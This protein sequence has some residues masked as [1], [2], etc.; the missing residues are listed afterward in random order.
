MN[1]PKS[2]FG[3]L[4]FNKRRVFSL[5]GKTSNLKNTVQNNRE[6][7]KNNS[8]Y[9]YS[10]INEY[11]DLIDEIDYEESDVEKIKLSEHLYLIIQVSKNGR[12]F[13]F[14]ILKKLKIQIIGIC[15]YFKLQ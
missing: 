13:D 1:S 15:I 10:N 12:S 6:E 5:V 3:N 2:I 14:T 11:S 9:K 7:E 8:L 4:K